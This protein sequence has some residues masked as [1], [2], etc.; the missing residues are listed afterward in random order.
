MV[1]FYT[2]K[3]TISSNFNNNSQYFQVDWYIVIHDEFYQRA[4][5][6][7]S[8]N[9]LGL[10]ILNIFGKHKPFRVPWTFLFF[11]LISKNYVI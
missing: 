10:P 11:F 1:F 6:K 4:Q 3:K 9:T 8:F 2:C 5:K 7:H